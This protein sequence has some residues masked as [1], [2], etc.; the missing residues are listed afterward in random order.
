MQIHKARRSRSLGSL[1]VVHPARSAIRTSLVACVLVMLTVM[2]QWSGVGPGWLADDSGAALANHTRIKMPFRSGQS[3]TIG[4]GYNTS[5]TEG[6]SHWNCDPATLMD[7]ISQTHSCRAPYQYKYSLDLAR[8][9][10]NTVGEPVLSPVDGTIRWIDEATGGMSINLGDG[11][12]VAF[13]HA[14]LAAGLTEGQPVTQG[15]V[16]GWVAN[17]GFANNG[18][19]P[20][21]HLALWQTTDGGNWSRNAVPFGGAQA[22]D[23]F[24]L[25]ALASST[26]N[27]YRGKAV[28][29]TNVETSSALP[30]APTLKSPATGTVYD[31]SSAYVTL[32]WNAVAG[33]TAYQAVINGTTYGPWLTATSWKTNLLP[34]GTYSW[35]VRARNATGIGPLSPTWV[36]TIDDGTTSAPEPAPTGDLAVTLSQTQGPAAATISVGGT[37]FASGE[38]VNLRW[39]SASATPL[40]TVT[41]SSGGAF[42][43]QVTV[44]DATRGAHAFYATGE[45]SGKQASASYT[46]TASLARTPTEG[47][48]G[49]Q[50]AVT[51]RGFGANEGV[52]L[53]WQSATGS[54]LGTATTNAAGTATLTITLPSASPGWNDYTGVGLTSGIR[55]W[56]AIKVLPSVT[57]SPTSASPGQQVTVTAQGFPAAKALSVAWNKT[58]TSPG[59][60]VCS[61]TASTSGTFSCIFTVPS[62]AAGAF[63]V[64]VTSVDGTT[65]AATLTV[66]G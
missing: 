33:A 47:V 39:D 35:Q 62:S 66:L 60:Q 64:T 57:L 2:A 5:P 56:G 59:T 1:H 36:F 40:T 25:P 46:L 53:T 54:T 49:T 38:R 32:G 48:P 63:P 55:A 58:A 3:W 18:G 29:S 43:A 42:T 23:G 11:Y 13:F 26:R 61:G 37:G 45:T 44:P 21:I 17:S 7:S 6:G 9:D 16:L 65:R 15:Q 31:A 20:H 24:D 27:Q 50:I 22:L 41:A 51:A 52:K 14:D 28:T 12:A 10:G 19:W 8:T 4:Q 30:P 34:A